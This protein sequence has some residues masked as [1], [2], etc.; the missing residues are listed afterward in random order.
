[1]FTFCVYIGTEEQGS[2]N[3]KTH[4][5]GGDAADGEGSPE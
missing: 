3:K 4:A 5:H 2:K 1:M